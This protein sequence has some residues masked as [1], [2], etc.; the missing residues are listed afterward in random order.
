MRVEVFT[1]CLSECS[2][3]R[4]VLFFDI[5]LSERG[6][7]FLLLQW[8]YFE[9]SRVGRPEVKTFR[10]VSEYEAKILK[11]IRA[12]I[13]TLC[14]IEITTK[15]CQTHYRVSGTSQWSV[16]CLSSPALLHDF[17]KTCY[18]PFHWASWCSGNAVDFILNILGP[19]VGRATACSHNCGTFCCDLLISP[20]EWRTV[21]YIWR[22][23]PS[24]SLPYQCS[25]RI[26]VS[27]PLFYAFLL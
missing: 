1:I 7:W 27:R 12:R 2:D 4:Y 21:S 10:S 13:L 8:H 18:M 3:V 25:H 16:V 19:D 23:T 5:S 17:M 24:E 26:L 22:M 6:C 20:T 15:K 14:G 9:C 11:E